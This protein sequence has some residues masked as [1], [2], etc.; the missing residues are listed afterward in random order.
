MTGSDRLRLEAHSTA[1]LSGARVKPAV[2]PPAPSGAPKIFYLNPLS[3]GRLDKWASAI[4]RARALGFSHLGVGPIFAPHSS[5]NIFASGDHDAAHPLFGGGPADAALKA[6]AEQ[7]ARE[8]MKL[9]LDLAATRVAADGKLARKHPDWFRP[10]RASG[11]SVDPRVP[12]EEA[13]VAVARFDDADAADAL[14]G[15]WTERLPRW[16]EAGVAGFRCLHPEEMPAAIWRRIMDAAR[17]AAPDVAFYAWT[18]GADWSKVAGLAAARFDGVFSSLPW[19]DRRASWFA[20]EYELLRRV[21]PVL[22]CP[23]APFGE[24]LAAKIAPQEMRAAY[25]QALRLAAATGRGMLIPSGFER[26][27]AEPMD[28]RK[29]IEEPFI[30]PERQIDLSDDI[31]A[32]LSLMDRLVNENNDGELRQ[33]TSPGDAVT[34]LL[35]AETDDARRAERAIGVLINPDLAHPR[36]CG[37]TLAPFVP[38]SPDDGRA[39]DDG[40][41]T[42]LA[43]GEVRIVE[44]H[45]PPAVKLRGRRKDQLLQAA[46]KAP[47]IVVDRISPSIDGG[48]FAVKRVVGDTIAVA[49]DVFADGHEV[50]AAELMWSAADE[51]DWHRV[52]MRLV[53]ND[54]WEASFTPL[55]LGRHLFTVEAWW[56]EYGTLCR[57]IELK[58]KAGVDFSVELQ[59]SRIVL[60]HA[61]ARA[62]TGRRRLLEGL[63][64]RVAKA[65]PD[66]QAAILTAPETRAAMAASDER[67][68]R[69]QHDP[70]PLDMDPQDAAFSAW[71]ELFPRS[72]TDDPRRHGTFD[73][74]IRHLPRIRAM[75]FDVLYFPP[76]HPI[77]RTNRKG[78][79]NSLK[80]GPEDFGSPYAIG[81]DEG[82]HDAIHP[83]L[84]TLADFQRLRAAAAAEGLEIA[85]DFAI[86][87]SPD[88]PWLKEH[89]GWF[90]RRPDGSIKFAENPPKKYE[91]IVNVDFYAEDALPELWVA[92]RDVVMFWVNEGIRIFRVD[93]PHTKPLPFWEW[94]IASVRSRHPDVLF[95]AEAFTRPKMM[96]RLGKIGFSQSYTY[97]TWRNTKQELQEYLTE[98]A[99]T[100]AADFYRPHFFVNTP[101]INP[102]FLQTSGRGGFLIRA[103]LAATLSGLWGVYSGFELCEAA[104]LPGREEYL[105]SEKYEI[106]VRNYAALGN[107]VAEI[108][109]LN[110]I[111]RA[112]PA[113][114]SHLGV[115]FYNAFNDRVMVYGKATA[116][117]RDMVL[118]AVSLDPYNV[119]E[120]DFEVPLWEWGLPDHAAVA[121][122]DLMHG[123]RA[124][125]TGKLQRVRLDP[126]QLPFAIWRIAP[127]TGGA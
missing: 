96:Y 89:P 71:Y 4:A 66:E 37:T 48:R 41:A 99:T 11:A 12:P 114:H 9:V 72:A 35:R 42:A 98:L 22:A 7:C 92:L 64:N 6:I 53:G 73:D 5:G 110:R 58:H 1:P 34:A 82:G 52:P 112:H 8:E 25:V 113:L 85:L 74:V 118:V 14:A 24:R 57:D 21:A 86:Q 103:A 122:E 78:P 19:W 84:G 43:P 107:I 68:F 105:D 54:R 59:E 126:S 93:N 27:A 10:L 15:W 29:C 20:D 67:R 65:A 39:A 108:S 75:G 125:W 102:Y 18:P 60:E 88:H 46:L 55:R 83:R 91:D 30:E 33:L 62:E 77:G 111:R 87:C 49:A 109:A 106:R 95:L 117:Q 45:R 97:F 81:A 127:V 63:L 56:D 119:Q 38:D 26:A 17:G 116:A 76:I 121:V 28:D 90:R 80:A 79:N 70:I 124:M 36:K 47:R 3:L 100:E 23:E 13:H 44:A 120:A 69:V 40:L 104:P 61:L 2:P 31:R 16:I 115:K 50:I 101:D 94:L 51:P 32:A 123:S